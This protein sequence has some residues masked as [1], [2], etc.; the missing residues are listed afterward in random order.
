[1]ISIGRIELFSDQVVE[2]VSI[3]TEPKAR[4]QYNNNDN[5]DNNNESEGVDIATSRMRSNRI[6]EAM[7]FA[8]RKLR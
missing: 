2:R 4:I 7:N 6:D 1:M 5:N 8:A 3:K